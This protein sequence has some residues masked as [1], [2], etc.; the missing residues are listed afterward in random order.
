MVSPSGQKTGTCQNLDID[1]LV[2]IALYIPAGTV[3]EMGE[4]GVNAHLALGLGKVV[5]RS[6]ILFVNRI[7]RPDGDG[8]IRIMAAWN[9]VSH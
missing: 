9:L 8:R 5:F 4:Q 3:A 1:S 6:S 7:I 2:G